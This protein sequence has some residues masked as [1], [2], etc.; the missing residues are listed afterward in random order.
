MNEV[1]VESLF[2][3]KVATTHIDGHDLVAEIIKQAVSADSGSNLSQPEDWAS[4]VITNFSN[5]YNFIP[6]E[7][8]GSV[9]EA[10]VSLL[11]KFL[12]SGAK[13]SSFDYEYFFNYYN[14]GHNQEVHAHLPHDF[15]CVW[16]L[17]GNPSDLYFYNANPNNTLE[18]PAVQFKGNVGDICMFP[19]RLPHFVKSC[20]EKGRITVAFNVKSFRF[21]A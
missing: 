12:P 17:S 20:A 4:Q 15:S 21:T 5:P 13:V 1:S 10:L 3:T 18:D 9:E 16:F 6:D 19:S 7:I 11:E 2:P 14:V 8:V